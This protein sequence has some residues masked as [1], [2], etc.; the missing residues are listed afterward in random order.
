MF[1]VM[2]L[3]G[4]MS[5]TLLL[6]M[7][8]PRAFTWVMEHKTAT[9]AASVFMAGAQQFAH[10]SVA[11]ELDTDTL[12]TQINV[13]ITNLFPIFA[14]GGGIAIAIVVISFIIRSIVEAFKGAGKLT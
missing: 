1:L 5:L 4:I 14:I 10:A 2:F 7:F 12:F 11:I 3:V 9:A 13:W 6:R 8:R